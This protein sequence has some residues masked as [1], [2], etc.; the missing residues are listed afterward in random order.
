MIVSI[1]LHPSGIQFFTGQSSIVPSLHRLKACI[2]K[3]FKPL[4]SLSHVT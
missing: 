3:Q 2:F 1:T 4:T